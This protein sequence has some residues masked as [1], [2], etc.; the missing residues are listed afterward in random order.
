MRE[1]FKS[2]SAVFPVLLQVKAGEE[3]VLLHLRTG[4]GYMDG[5]WDFAG[6][7]H[8]EEGETASQAVCRECGEEIGVIVRPENTRFLHVAHRLDERTYYDLYF[9]VCAWEGEPGINEPDKCAAL[10]WFAVDQLPRNMIPCRRRALELWRAGTAYS[11]II[12]LEEETP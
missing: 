1:H 4:T 12:G 8:V 7:G 10:E 2:L 5:W 6:S 11:E 3:Q 9:Q